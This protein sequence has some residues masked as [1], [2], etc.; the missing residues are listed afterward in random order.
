VRRF[1]FFL[2]W[3]LVL[4]TFA[5]AIGIRVAGMSY[6]MSHIDPVSDGGLKEGF[7]VGLRHGLASRS[8]SFAFMLRYWH[9]TLAGALL[10]AAAGSLPGVLP[11]T[12]KPRV[13]EPP[14]LPPPGP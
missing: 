14:P 2:L 5:M 11:G 13:T 7:Q 1:A 6:S 9:V 3:T 12:G 4:W 8:A 10:L